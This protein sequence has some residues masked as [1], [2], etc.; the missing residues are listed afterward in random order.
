M[1]RSMQQRSRSIGRWYLDGDVLAGP[2]G[3]FAVTGELYGRCPTTSR[4]HWWSPRRLPCWA[5]PE[6]VA[7]AASTLRR[8]HTASPRSVNST[9]RPT[10][11]T[12]RPRPSCNAVGATRFDRVVLIA[13]GQQGHRSDTDGVGVRP[14]RTSS[15]SVTGR[16]DRTGLRSGHPGR[17]RR[18]HGGAVSA[19]RQL[20]ASSV[21]VLL[22]PGCAS[23]D[24]Y[25]NYGERGD[26]LPGHCGGSLIATQPRS[27]KVRQGAARRRH[28]T[29]GRLRTDV[30]PA[31]RSAPHHGL[32]CPVRRHV[33]PHR[34]RCRHGVVGQC[35]VQHRRDRERL[36]FIPAPVDVVAI[37]AI[38]MLGTMRVDTTGGASSPPRRSSGA[39]C[40]SSSSSFRGFR[41]SANGATRWLGVGPFTMQPSELPA[42]IVLFAADCWVGR[43][44]H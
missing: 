32:S 2:D 11:T 22:S 20:A 35:G 30:V 25:R 19:A 5:P 14:G 34:A 28:P 15:R 3:P 27:R 40:C 43:V 7:R 1:S 29:A 4:T 23:F 9:D 12:P 33:D 44:G 13:G 31:A 39:A 24:W 17:H 6:A 41:L 26:D 38:V 42:A 8:W 36:E 16:R 18:R 21:P 37:G 10:T